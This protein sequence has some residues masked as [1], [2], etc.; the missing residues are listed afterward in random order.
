MQNKKKYYIIIDK[1]IYFAMTI[2][3]KALVDNFPDNILEE[4]KIK[5]NDEIYGIKEGKNLYLVTPTPLF[6]EN[7]DEIIKNFKNY[8]ILQNDRFIQV[9][10]NI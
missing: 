6:F 5:P 3:E 10:K 4:N 2:Q 1:K 7:K 9:L 8:K